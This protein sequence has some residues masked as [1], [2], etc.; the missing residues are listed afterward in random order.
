MSMKPE[1]SSAVPPRRW[2]AALVILVAA[3]SFGAQPALSGHA[4]PDVQLSAIAGRARP[5]DLVKSSVSKVLA[6]VQ[7]RPAAGHESGQRRAEIR[8]VAD[9][10]FDFNEM[11]QLILSQHWSA[12]SPRDQEEFVR[13]TALLERSYLSTIENYAGERITFLGES[14]NGA[15]A[16]VWSRITTDRRVE[17]SIDYRLID[18]GY[19]W[20]VYDVVL[21]GM[22]LVSN[23]RSQF[24]SI[25]RTSSFEELLARLRNR[26][27]EAHVIPR[28]GRAP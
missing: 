24:N 2:N 4:V 13:L 16:Q 9:G 3:V 10:F 5:L 12:Q 8:Q 21:E 18:R 22:S 7:S 14:I 28:V 11:A 1:L 17:I 6:V 20:A 27:I 19:R 15:Y 26:Q 25:V 23:Y